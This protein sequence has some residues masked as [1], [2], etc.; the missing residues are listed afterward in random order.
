MKT[1]TTTNLNIRNDATFDNVDS[2]LERKIGLV[3]EGLSHQYSDRLHKIPKDNAIAI[4]D[5]ILYMKTEINLSHNHIKNNIMVLSLLSQFHNNKKSFKQMTRE[6]ILSYLNRLRKPESDDPLHK[7]VGS[8]N[9]YRT[10]ILK[11][12]KWL[13]HPDL[14]VSKRPKPHVVENIPQLKRK[15]Q[16]IYKP[17]DLWAIEDD[18]LF[19]KYCPSIRDKCYHMISRDTGC[20]PHEILKLKIKDIVFKTVTERNQQYAQVLINGKT[21]SRHIPLINSIPYVKDWLDQHPQQ[22]N[23]N[24]PL[25]C[26]YNKSLGRR[27][28][29]MAITKLYDRYKLGLF[30]KLLDS[31]SVSVEDKQKI[32]ELLKKPW[33]PYIRR[34]SA[35]TE[36]SG[37]LKEHHLRQ[38]AGWSLSL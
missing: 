15:E 29:P 19:L 23:P 6:D 30:A 35:L 24:S 11:F 22:G 21:G 31:P 1:T 28:N 34:H 14:E 17:S 10:L 2:V 16:S 5:F 13:Y 32:K 12:F 38:Y 25:I 8:Y 7:W 33:N 36:K 37:I 20:R 3:A 4:T 9:L 18:L 26:G 27:L